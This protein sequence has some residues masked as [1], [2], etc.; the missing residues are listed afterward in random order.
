MD[1]LSNPIIADELAEC[2]S[3][4]DLIRIAFTSSFHKGLYGEK[5]TE[6]TVCGVNFRPKNGH[7]CIMIIRSLDD[8]CNLLNFI[9]TNCVYHINTLSGSSNILSKDI[10]WYFIGES[11]RN[12][13]FDPY[14]FQIKSFDNFVTNSDCEVFHNRRFRC[15]FE[16]G[17]RL[18]SLIR[19]VGQHRLLIGDGV[20]V[21]KDDV[22]EYKAV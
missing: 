9:N 21:V 12:M 11:H 7:S 13:F 8:A 6:C 18:G 17:T 4:K 14:F 5:I 22:I 19:R 1:I 16:S 2:V 20:F 3:L 10:P 15:T